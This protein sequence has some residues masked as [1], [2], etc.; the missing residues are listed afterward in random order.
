MIVSATEN[1]KAMKK[2][3]LFTIAVF[4]SIAGFSQNR[5]SSS[6]SWNNS[7]F[8]EKEII[9]ELK[10]YPNPCKTNLVNIV[11]NTSKIS[12]I[13]LVNIT[14]KQVIS[15]KFI[16]P[17]NKTQLQLKDIKNGM[18]LLKVKSTENKTVVKKFIISKE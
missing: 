8:D 1:I 10:I 3:L 9:P 13:Q 5:I 2:I 7:F 15:K 6:A 18:Y 16:F 14:G 4:I 12:E 11:F 17:E